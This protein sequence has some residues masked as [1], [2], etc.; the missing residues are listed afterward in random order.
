V[1]LD[2]FKKNLSSLQSFSDVKA[3][4]S[5]A[6]TN[7]QNTDVQFAVPVELSSKLKEQFVPQEQLVT[8]EE[9]AATHEKTNDQVWRMIRSGELPAS[10]SQGKLMIADPNNELALE[11]LEGTWNTRNLP[12][13]RSGAST[14]DSTG[15]TLPNTSDIANFAN[16]E[17]A[18][19]ID[20]LSL[21]KDENREVLKVA[22]DSIQRIS[23]I[24]EKLASSKDRLLSERESR[25]SE[26]SH[27]ISAQNQTISDL[28]SQLNISDDESL[29]LKK[30]IE[31]L[32]ILTCALSEDN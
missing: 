2:E 19:L 13:V 16:N 31:D 29:K 30:S 28:K 12:V 3:P 11:A 6:L 10:Y 5:S 15:A 1:D 26:Q 9:Y 22:Q 20:H 24:A 8:I 17:L 18:L 27:C 25:L 14:S 7:S 21:A 23:E 4:I 32:E